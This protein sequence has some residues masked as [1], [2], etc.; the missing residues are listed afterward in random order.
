MREGEKTY[1]FLVLFH[2]LL[3]VAIF[4]VPFLSKIYGLAIFFVGL[5]YVF[6]YKNKD[7]EALYVCAYFVGSEVILRMT[8][9]N[10]L[11]EYSKYSVIFFILMGMYYR[12]FSKYAVSYWVYMVL[13]I[14]GVV[15]SMISL[16]YDL[17]LRKSIAFNISGPLCLGISALYMYNRRVTLEQINKIVLMLGLPVI[18]CAVYLFFYTPSIR[19]VITGTGS[20]FETSGGFGPNQ[21]STMLGLGVFVFVTRLVFASSNKWVIAVNLILLFNITYR[22]LVTFS[23]GGMITAAVMIFVFIFIIY[24]KINSQGKAKMNFLIV[25]VSILM[26][27]VWGYTT[28]QTGGLIENRYANQDAK[29]RVKESKL[30]GREDIMASDM[31]M[32]MENPFFGVGVAKSARYRENLSGKLILAHNEVTRMLAEHGSLGIA[33]LFI[34]IFTPLILYLKNKQHI[35]M[36]CF[37]VFWSLT[38]NHAAMRL[39]APGFIYALSIL[40][41]YRNEDIVHRE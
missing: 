40:K 29:G 30:S 41:V 9:G 8:A 4:I 10:L 39:A 28:S 35:Y 17:A 3:G 22:G 34:L 19:D 21:V 11:Y 26:I 12:G 6:K 1:L 7:Q 23:R 25:F 13:L 5:Y 16:D 14:P 27:G 33:A 18:T 24:T 31:K 20:N 32:F 36:L 15:V 38:I 2:A 37:F